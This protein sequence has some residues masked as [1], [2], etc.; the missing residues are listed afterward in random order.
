[1]VHRYL[2]R[3]ASLAPTS[4]SYFRWVSCHSRF[5][6]DPIDSRQ[7]WFC[8]WLVHVIVTAVTYYLFHARFSFLIVIDLI[9]LRHTEKTLIDTLR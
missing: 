3:L 8:S 1:M 2:S 5:F 7:R 9:Q 6:P 4:N